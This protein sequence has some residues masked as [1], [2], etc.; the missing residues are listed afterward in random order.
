MRGVIDRRGFDQLEDAGTIGGVVDSSFGIDETSTVDRILRWI[1]ELAPS[2][3]FFA[4]YLPIAGHHPYA[5]NAAGPIS[6]EHGVHAISQCA[7]RE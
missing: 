5:T 6:W 3:R 1:D 4:T 2:D 7:A